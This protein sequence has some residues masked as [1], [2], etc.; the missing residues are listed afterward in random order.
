N[1]NFSTGALYTIDK[2]A[3]TAGSLVAANVTTGGGTTYSFTVT[4][5]D[6]LGIDNTSIGNGNILVSGPGGF[7]PLAT[8]VSVTP[9]GN[10]MPRTATYQITAPGGTW[11]IA[12][13]GTYSVAVEANQV[14][15]SAGNSVGV[16]SLGSFLVDLKYTTYL[17]LVRS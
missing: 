16:I 15:D 3:P 4:F 13:R 2:I 5:S 9:A 17:P 12:D 14:F 1:G 7:V 6:N 11:D 8:V 10:G